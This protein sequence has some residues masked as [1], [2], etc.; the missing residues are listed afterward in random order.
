MTLVEKIAA[1]ITAAMKAKEAAKLE[2]L[3]GAKSALQL[4][5]IEA[6]RPL[7]DAE[8]AKILE[9]LIKQ[10]KEAVEMFE[11]GGRQ[12]LADKDKGQIV[13]LES[14]L[15]KGVT[16]E[17]LEAAVAAAVAETN[18][19]EPKHQG[20]VMKAVMAKLAGARVDGKEVAALVSAKL[21][22]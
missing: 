11:K 8:A 7:T 10:R 21:K 9:T 18:A 1:D 2:A 17:A 14:Y 13:V 20:A 15:P 22:K 12:E 3:R 6:A 5:E 16:R 19:T 4:K